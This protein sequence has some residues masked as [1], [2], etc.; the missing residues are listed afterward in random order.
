MQIL[1]DHAEMAMPCPDIVKMGA[2]PSVEWCEAERALTI[3]GWQTVFELGAPGYGLLVRGSGHISFMDLPFL[4]AVPGSMI[5]AGLALVRIDAARAW[6]VICDSL[7]A[8]FDRH[9]RDAD[10]PLLHG[11]SAEMPE[12]L[13]GPPRDLIAALGPRA[14]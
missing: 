14:T 7:L 4:P 3:G 1:A 11:P 12:L 5:E 6:R 13:F 8:F 2:Y 10:A 9:V